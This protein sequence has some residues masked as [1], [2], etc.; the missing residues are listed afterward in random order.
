MGQTSAAPYAVVWASAPAGG[1]SL[2]AVAVDN[3]GA[4]ATSAPVSVTL[5]APSGVSGGLAL[6]GANQYVTFGTATNLDAATFTLELWFNWTGGG[7]T[8]STGSGGVSAIPLIA[9]ARGEYDGDDR[10]GNYILGIRASDSVLID[11]EKGRFRTFLLTALK[12]FMATEWQ[13]ARAQKRGG[14]RQ[15]QPLDTALAE[16][17]YATEPGAGLSPDRLY[18]RRWALTLLDNALVRLQ[19]EFT[20]A[21]KAVDYDALKPWLTADRGEIRYGEL[22]ATLNRDEG[23]ARVAVHRFRKR[24][25]ELFRNEV[26]Q[27]VARPADVED[28]TR[29]LMAALA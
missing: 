5:S 21:G 13:R 18:Q 19:Q 23:A 2:Y 7:A 22:A 24:Y 28:E 10:D 9:K 17:L 8:A 12:R 15:F 29:H 27:T 14:D 26:A 16:R 4:R 6:N 20:Q 25:R 3:T 1:Y 11:R